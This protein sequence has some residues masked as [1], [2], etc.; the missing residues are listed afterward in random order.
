M[1]PR[2]V[3]GLSAE[4]KARLRGDQKAQIGKARSGNRWMH[5]AELVALSTK[6]ARQRG[7]H[8]RKR[9]GAR[10]AL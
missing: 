7:T 8:R 2:A 9:N 10:I 6:R 1:K 3:N 4:A 5:P